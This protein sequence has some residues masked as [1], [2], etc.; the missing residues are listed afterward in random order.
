MNNEDWFD[1]IWFGSW[2]RAVLPCPKGGIHSACDF[3]FSEQMSFVLLFRSLS[4]ENKMYLRKDWSLFLDWPPS[5]WHPRAWSHHLSTGDPVSLG[6]RWPGGG[7]LSPQGRPQCPTWEDCSEW[8]TGKPWE[9]CLER[10]MGKPLKGRLWC[11][12][13]LYKLMAHKPW[14]RCWGGTGKPWEGC[15]HWGRV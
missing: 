12:A 15:L 1:L 5:N 14:R 4:N 11:S 13:Y 8:R 9:L 3:L 6:H 2:E 10:R 7:D